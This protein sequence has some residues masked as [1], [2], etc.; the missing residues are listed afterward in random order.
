MFRSAFL[1]GCLLLAGS[2]ALGCSHPVSQATPPTPEPEIG[3]R[4][5]ANTCG[6]ITGRVVW[7]GPIP[8]VPPF[9]APYVPRPESGIALG[10]HTWPNH[11]VPVV[12]KDRT[13][14][15]AVV[16]LKEVEP[17]RSRPWDHEPVI[18]EIEKHQ[19]LVRQGQQRSLV[20]FVQRGRAIDMVSRDPFFHSILAR[21]AAF[22][23]MPFPDANVVRSRRL[24]RQGIVELTSGCGA[25]W[26]TGFLFVDDHP[27]YSRT[28]GG[29][30]TLA[31]VPAGTYQLVCWHPDWRELSRELDGDTWEVASIEC[32]PA[33]TI[34]QT[35]TVEAGKTSPVDLVFPSP[36]QGRR[37]Q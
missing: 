7:D 20:G 17:N 9:R 19:L 32:R 3:G 1:P 16:F 8:S 33:L 36:I 23:S 15:S 22:F 5:N 34:E 18:V 11:R 25:F 35:V 30:F 27:Y 4:F 26:M 37:P 6:T 24:D 12:G 10:R 29:Q 14:S 21:G 13:L 31:Q 2:L 28:P